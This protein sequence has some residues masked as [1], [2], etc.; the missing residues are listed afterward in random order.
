M[1]SFALFFIS[2]YCCM[3]AIAY[4]FTTFF[5]SGSFAILGAI[6][7]S[8]TVES[9]STLASQPSTGFII[10]VILLGIMAAISA[11]G[12]QV[13][14]W[15]FYI[16]VG[17]FML[18]TFLIIIVFVATPHSSFVSAR[19]GYSSS[20]GTTYQGLIDTASKSGWAPSVSPIAAVAA[21]PITLINY[22]GFTYSAYTAGEIKNVAKSLNRSIFAC[23]GIGTI[24]GLALLM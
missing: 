12:K 7:G 11:S 21:L 10:A 3:S 24:M 16:L 4:T 19:N 18:A 13:L 5:L 2:F 9:W 20:L 1:T 22:G 8:K 14:R 6:T 15:T 23:L 17:W